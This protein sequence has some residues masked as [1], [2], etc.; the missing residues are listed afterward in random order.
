[1]TLLSL[2]LTTVGRLRKTYSGRVAGPS[3]DKCCRPVTGERLMGVWPMPGENLGARLTVGIDGSFGV[4]HYALL[5]YT[6]SPAMTRSGIPAKAPHHSSTEDMLSRG[7]RRACNSD[8]AD[9]ALKA[10]PADGSILCR[11]SVD[12][13]V[14]LSIDGH[15]V[16]SRRFDP[17][18]DESALWVKAA[19]TRGVTPISGDH[20]LIT[21]TGVDPTVAANKVALVTAKIPTA[22]I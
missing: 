7:F 17:K 8:Y 22:W 5:A 18:E 14:S 21:E 20:L 6:T 3:S 16:W 9:I 1:M 12:G 2:Q 19:Q 13:L 11:A 10:Q 4:L 15:R